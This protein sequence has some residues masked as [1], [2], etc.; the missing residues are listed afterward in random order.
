[1]LSLE[2]S[3]VRKKGDT[4][5]ELTKMGW[6]IMSPGTE[7][8]RNR[9]RL[10]QTSQ[11]DYVEWTFLDLLMQLRSDQTI[12][13]AEF[14]EQLHRDQEGW[15]ETGLPWQANHPKLPNNK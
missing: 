12:V 8:D 10:T 7:F 2:S 9:V 3:P 13:H 5:A 11:S 1:M 6:F 15:H 14:K 4:I